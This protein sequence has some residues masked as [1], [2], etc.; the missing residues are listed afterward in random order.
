MNFLARN[1]EFL[2]YIEIWNETES[3]LMKSLI[4]KG[5]IINLCIIKNI[6]I[7]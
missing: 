1:K 5:C 2:K 6:L 7:Q 3:F 4:K